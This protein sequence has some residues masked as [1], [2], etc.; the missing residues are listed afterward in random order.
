[1]AMAAAT[2]SWPWLWNALSVRSGP[3]V[4]GARPAEAPQTPKRTLVQDNFAAEL[5]TGDHLD[6][7]VAQLLN[8][9]RVA[10]LMRP[11]L[12]HSVQLKHLQLAQ[13][14]LVETTSLVPAGDV[15]M[16]SRSLESGGYDGAAGRTLIRVEP[17]L[18]DRFAVTNRDYQ[19]FVDA[20]GYEQLD[21]WEASLGPSIGDF[22]DKS[23]QPGPRYWLEGRHS[24]YLA[25][26]P[27]VGVNW[28]E[29][30]AYARWVG[31]R[32][33][34]DEQWVKAGVWPV[35][36]CGVPQQRRYPW[37]D[38][39]DRTCANVCGSGRN[40]T[41]PVDD[42]SGGVSVGGV[43]QLCGNVWE[44]T[45]SAWGAWEPQSKAAE[46]DMAMRSLRGGAFDTYF[47]NQTA[48]QFQSGDDPLAR[49]HNVG[50]RCALPCSDV[51]QQQPPMA[52]KGETSV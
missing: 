7:L 40:G 50:F 17:V 8:Q 19:Q 11:E 51:A 14:V 13:R 46:S 21:L 28:Y 5:I 15:L 4:R 24:P 33:P 42:F 41:A 22:V 31:K 44:W 16:H 30:S 26:H 10:L 23:A 1:M 9:G 35:A 39:F 37:G 45:S 6:R 49:R 25:E 27:V 29:A 20:G 18:L 38:T 34:T 3:T 47:E 36:T 48:C 43:H 32:L 12:R 52:A 2:F